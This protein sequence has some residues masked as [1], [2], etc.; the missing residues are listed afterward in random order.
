MP[1]C[2]AGQNSTRGA[3]RTHGWR[4]ALVFVA[5][6][7]V[8]VDLQHAQIFVFFVKAETSGGVRLCS[9]PIVD[10]EFAVVHQGAPAGEQL[11]DYFVERSVHCV[12]RRQGVDADF[13]VRLD[14]QFLVVKL[15]IRLAARIAV[16]PLRVPC[17]IAV[18]RSSGTGKI[19]AR[20]VS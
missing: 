19:T 3:W 9:P 17:C 6:V 15:Q 20:D 13:F 11:G 14:L 10:R 18:V 4:I 7:R 2:T 12:D 5:Q 8:G 16:G 1:T